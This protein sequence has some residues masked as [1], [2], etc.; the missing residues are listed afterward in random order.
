MIFA[1]EMLRRLGFS[2]DDMR[3]VAGN[4]EGVGP[5][6]FIRLQAQGKTFDWIIAR[7]VAGVSDTVF[8]TEFLDAIQVWNKNKGVE[9]NTWGYFQSSILNT[10]DVGLVTALQAKGFVLPCAVN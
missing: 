4:G 1:M 6:Y 9:N 8:Q 5:C 10:M 7:Q 3:P 2:L